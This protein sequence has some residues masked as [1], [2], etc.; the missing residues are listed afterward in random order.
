M[1]P[2]WLHL[3][4]FTSLLFASIV[5]LRLALGTIAGIMLAAVILVVRLLWFLYR[6]TEAFTITLWSLTS[7]MA[8]RIENAHQSRTIAKGS[9]HA[10]RLL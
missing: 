2:R 5:A 9:R 7:E 1:K 8:E 3:L 6:S 10:T 4:I